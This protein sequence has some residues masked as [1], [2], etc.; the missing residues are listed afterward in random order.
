MPV[1]SGGARTRR[2][3]VAFA[4]MAQRIPVRHREQ[5]QFLLS[6]AAEIEHNLMCCYLLER[7]DELPF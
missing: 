5:I 6:E 7:D 1:R 3:P 4:T 2:A